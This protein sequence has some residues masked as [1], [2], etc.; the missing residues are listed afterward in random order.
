MS[1]IQ[2]GQKG[3]PHRGFQALLS[4]GGSRHGCDYLPPT[5][6]WVRPQEADDSPLSAS[7]GPPGL[8]GSGPGSHPPGPLALPLSCWPQEPEIW[9]VP[10]GHRRVTGRK[11]QLMVEAH[12]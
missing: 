3:R 6:S 5:P 9:V 8:L 12:P 10:A 2:P 1:W 4:P 7:W 11:G